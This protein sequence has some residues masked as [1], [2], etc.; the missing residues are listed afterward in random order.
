MTL[1]DLLTIALAR[2]ASDLH[3]AA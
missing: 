2:Q 3:L 1:T